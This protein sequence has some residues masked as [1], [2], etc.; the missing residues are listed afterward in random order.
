M[1]LMTALRPEKKVEPKVTG[2]LLWGWMPRIEWDKDD[3]VSVRRAEL[4]FYGGL[5]A[6]MAAFETVEVQG[7]GG[8]PVKEEVST[9]S[10]NPETEQIRMTAQFAGG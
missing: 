6:G 7:W 2:R 1:S 4:E 8:A 3:P 10:F 5:N 9:R